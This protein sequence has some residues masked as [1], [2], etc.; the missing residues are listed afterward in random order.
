MADQN[1]PTPIS[2]VSSGSSVTNYIPAVGDVVEFDRHGVVYSGLVRTDGDMVWGAK[3]KIKAMKSGY[4]L[5]WTSL[6]HCSDTD[7]YRL[8]E[9]TGL[10]LEWEDASKEL[11]NRFS[12]PTFTGSYAERQKQW[13]EHHG[14]K[15]GDKVRVV[16]EFS[17]EEGGCDVG[18]PAPKM[19]FV[20][21]TYGI[22]DVDPRS[23]QLDTG[24]SMH[25]WFPYFALEPA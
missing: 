5:M 15:V 1:V 9:S 21:K 16:R 2:D 8:V 7:E 6:I 25:S 23:I 4:D 3:S 17:L 22:T 19:A 10:D 11:I 14:L 24:N 18:C 13:I 20:G 12:A